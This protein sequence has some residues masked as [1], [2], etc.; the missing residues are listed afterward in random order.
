MLSRLSCYF[1][2][3]LSCSLYLA[4]LNFQTA[5]VAKVKTHGHVFL[6]ATVSQLVNKQNLSKPLNKQ[7]L[8]KPHKESAGTGAVKFALVLHSS[9]SPQ[10]L[11]AV[12]GTWFQ[13][14]S[15][16]LGIIAFGKALNVGS[17]PLL[18]TDFVS[19]VEGN[20][21]LRTRC[22]FLRAYDKF[23]NSTFFAKFDDDSYVYTRELVKAV[24][25]AHQSDRQKRYFGYPI[26]LSGLGEFGSGGAGY[27]LHRSLVDMLRG[28]NPPHQEFEDASVAHCL[29]QGG[30][31]LVDLLGLHPHHPFQM[32]AWDKGK[33]PSDRPRSVRFFA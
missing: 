3:L 14:V 30:V 8:S 4:F 31:G 12:L 20:D 16:D 5:T 10:R 2:V 6:H 32:L 23:P 1:L 22:A 29:K 25:T 21:F 17:R 33:H 26:E 18:N 13:T 15:S 9:G 11:D 24:T 19:C 7:N 27:V 28:C